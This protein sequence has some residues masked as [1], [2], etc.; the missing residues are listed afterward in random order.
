MGPDQSRQ[1]ETCHPTQFTW[2]PSW[3]NTEK[4]IA[5]L[6][7][8]TSIQPLMHWDW[9]HIYDSAK[10]T[11]IGSGIKSLRLSDAY[12]SVDCT[13]IGSDKGL[14]PAWCQAIIWTNAWILLI[15]TLWTNFSQILRVIRIFSFKKMHLK[16]SSGKR[17]PF[18]LD[19]IVLTLKRPGL[20]GWLRPTQFKSRL[21]WVGSA[22]QVR[23][24]C[25][26][27]AAQAFI[28]ALAGCVPRSLQYAV[29]G[30]RNSRPAHFAAHALD[31]LATHESP[32]LTQLST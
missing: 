21:D 25:V 6:I 11:I 30:P 1:G 28:H 18:C 13:I 8:I 16:M 24:Y 29:C 10:K 26:D 3:G 14:L 9:W 27:S 20:C 32:S 5:Y 12:A 19:L 4:A 31:V 23:R 17:R 22:A 7:F 2:Q 15:R